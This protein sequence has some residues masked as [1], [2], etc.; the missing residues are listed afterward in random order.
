MSERPSWK[1]PPKPN[2]NDVVSERVAYLQE[3]DQKVSTY[4]RA[5]RRGGAGIPRDV[6]YSM[7]MAIPNQ[8]KKR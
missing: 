8:K 7:K 3:R 1:K 4:G 6:I 2:P 5:A